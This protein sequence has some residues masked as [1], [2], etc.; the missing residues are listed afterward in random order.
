MYINYD[1]ESISES[2]F[3]R[4]E[5]LNDNASTIPNP[6]VEDD[7]STQIVA[8]R[9]S[10]IIVVL[11]WYIYG[12]YG[13]FCLRGL[14]RHKNYN[15]IFPLAATLFAFANNTNDIVN[16][17]YHKSNCYPFWLIFVISATLNWA[18]ISWLQAYRLAL[19]SKIYLSKIASIIITTMAI[20]FSS[21]YCTFYFLNLSLFDY[22]KT[23]VLGCGVTNPGTWTP[24]IM[25]SDIVDSFFSL[26]SICIIVFKSINH[27]KELNTRNE[28]LNDL[29]GEGIVELF[30]IAVAKIV[31]YPLIHITSSVPGLDFFWDVLSIIVIIS[32]YNLVNFPYEHSDIN[33]R[34]NRFSIRKNVFKFLD[35]TI[36]HSASGSYSDNASNIRVN[37][38]SDN[39]YKSSLLNYGNSTIIKTDT[40]VKN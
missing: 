23:D 31:I 30:I 1:M 35:S 14:I 16:Y 36:S 34:G 2:L 18:P 33:R 21:I 32:A 13:I 37:R 5:E 26:T 3:K 28:K 24:F 17:V 22:T 20:I 29:V 10:T 9:F 6:N 11:S 40:T 38:N 19:I 15:F 25:I 4:D 8:T 12:K 39:N 27:L 7:N